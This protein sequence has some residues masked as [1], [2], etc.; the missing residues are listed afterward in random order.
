VNVSDA[1]AQRFSARAF[2][3]DPVPGEI[4]R[5]ILDAA[6]RTPSGGNLQPW[7]VYVLGG[8]TL[9]AF[10]NLIADK[11]DNGVSEAPEYNVYP[12]SLWEP[13]RT[14]RHEAGALRYK[15]LGV[16]DKDSVGNKALLR[17]NYEF[18]GAPVGLFFCLDRRCGPPQWSD[19]GMYILSVMLLAVERDLDTCAQEIWSNWPRAVADLACNTTIPW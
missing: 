10:K 1:V 15:A 11:F 16:A 2:R 4:V 13:L 14:R 8:E 18:F 7:R 5:D 19:L 12:P 6:R 9:A 3:Q 17:K